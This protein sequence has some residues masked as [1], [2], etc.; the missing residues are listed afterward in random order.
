M[1][2]R[3]LNSPNSDW[4]KSFAASVVSFGAYILEIPAGLGIDPLIGAFHYNIVFPNVPTGLALCPSTPE[5][6][7][8]SFSVGVNGTVASVAQIPTGVGRPGTA[9]L[10]STRASTTGALSTV[11]LTDDI[12]GAGVKWT[13]GDFS[14][15]CG[16]IAAGPADINFTCGDG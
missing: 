12:N 16:P 14:R 5:S 2:G 15:L 11:F 6:P 3:L 13:G 7:G 9:Q 1:Q 8:I 4:D 10:R